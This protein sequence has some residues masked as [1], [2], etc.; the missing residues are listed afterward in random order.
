MTAIEQDITTFP[1]GGGQLGALVRAFDWSR[2]RLG[3]LAFWPQS[4][5]TAVDIVLQSPLPMVML[6]GA[7]G[8]MIYNDAYSVF[9]GERHPQLLGAPVL[10]G[11][12]EVADFNREVM[13][14][15]LAGRSLSFQDQQ[16]VLRRFGKPESVWMDLNYSPVLDETGKPAGV[17]AIVI[18][19]TERVRTQQALR[20]REAELAR[21]Q[22]IGRI[23]GLEVD[24]ETGFRNRRSAEYLTLHGLPP[25]ATHETHEAW[26]A[27]IHPDDREQTERHFIESV[28]GSA[29]DYAAEY[30]IIRPS[31]G[32]VR[33]IAAKAVIERAPD[34]HAV[35]LVGAHS[36]ITERK[37][38]EEALRESEARFRVMADSAPALI[39]AT[40]EDGELTFANQRHEIEF[41]LNPHG[42]QRGDLLE[43][44]V[45]EDRATFADNFRQAFA[46]H[47][48]FKAQIR[49]Y[50]RRGELRWLRCEGLP[51]YDGAG[52]FLG[53]VGCNVDVTEAQLAAD[54]LEALVRERTQ[55]RDSIW[56]NSSELMAVAGF[57]GYLKSANPAWTHTLGFDRQTLLSRPFTELVHPDDLKGSAHI[58]A[59]LKDGLAVTDFEN[60]LVHVDGSYRL[61]SWTAVPGDG[62]FHAIG[63][64]ITQQRATEE[65]LRQAQKMEALGQL[66]G[67]IAHD[68]NNL[69]QGIA[70][71]LDLIKSRI[72]KGRTGDIDRFIAAAA[73]STNRAA[74]LT[75]RLL[76]FARRQPLDPRS[77][78]V[79]PLPTSMEELVRRTIGESIEMKFVLQRDLWSTLCDRNQLENCILNLVI[80]A[81]DAMPGGGTLTIETRNLEVGPTFAFGRS[82][83]APGEYVCIS[84][85]D[86]GIGMTRD[87]LDRVF[88]PFFTTKPLGQGTG[89]GLSMIF[90]FVRQSAGDIKISS[91]VGRGT[92]VT[93]V[94][95]RYSGHT[96]TDVETSG[97]AGDEKASTGSIILVVEDE[98][99]VRGLIVDVLT[100]LGYRTLEAHD[101]PSALAI[102]QSPQTV[103]LLISDIGLP[104]LNGRQVAD[105]A[106]SL[107][108]NLRV[109]F[110]TG[111]AEKAALSEG[112]LDAGMEMIVKPF[113]IDA[114]TERVRAMIETD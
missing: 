87:V 40:D 88:D 95:P 85:A 34:G 91:M 62:V 29:R 61:I 37:R 101:G 20:E 18:E 70:G 16:L 74:A 64:D 28:A 5:R 15:V 52:N 71:S 1:R 54:A 73:T 60:R 78:A 72:A 76:A 14:A 59:T 46:A 12:A 104:G 51:R 3:P 66:T 17:L 23:G 69:L 41:G 35:R 94:L 39:W 21:V 30:R 2:T 10:E 93:I 111:Y 98:P 100:E 110:M 108:P 68:F 114:L 84:V 45:P 102:L 57:D 75:H 55:E 99:V 32:Q 24:L 50:N 36:D 6:W 7:D 82:D 27:R 106:R 105:A 58:I 113:S 49:V 92:T 77:V 9:A 19:T 86:T 65:A 8:V 89:L 44:V 31:D 109:L 11:W 103:D 56:N 22:Q 107:R 53:Y 63:R 90:G 42:L 81:R 112:A 43:I 97:A 26:V 79:N 47:A 33:W 80:N 83:L 96:D 67:G 38:A 25:D 13:R 48:P 4:L